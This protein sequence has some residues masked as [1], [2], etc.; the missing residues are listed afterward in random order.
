MGDH[1]ESYGVST[2]T[3]R[4]S[5]LR[6]MSNKMEDYTDEYTTNYIKLVRLEKMTLRKME[7]KI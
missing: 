2:A 7:L 4:A 1:Q 3:A 6:T 5:Q